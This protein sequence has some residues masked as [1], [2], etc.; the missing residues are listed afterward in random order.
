MTLRAIGWANAIVLRLVLLYFAQGVTVVVN[1]GMCIS[2]FPT[3]LKPPKCSMAA[4]GVRTTE[5]AGVV[6]GS[7]RIMLSKEMVMR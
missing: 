5:P 1:E 3:G 7:L 6:S 2:V 4:K